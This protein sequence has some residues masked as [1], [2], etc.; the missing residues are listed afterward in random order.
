MDLKLSAQMQDRLQRRADF[1]GCSVEELVTQWLEQEEAAFQIP[2]QAIL[3]YAHDVIAL[4]DHDLRHVYINA[5][6]QVITG[7]APEAYLGRTAREMGMPEPAATQWE[8]AGASVFTTGE[9]A[10][11]D[12][13]F[14]VQGKN[15]F[16]EA[17]LSPIFDASGEVQY[18]L[19][20]ARDITDRKQIE[21]DLR[22]SEARLAQAQKIAH[23]AHWEWNVQTGETI[24][25]DEFCS[26]C[27]IDPTTE[28]PSLELG[29]SLIH[30]DDRQKAE[31]AIEASMRTGQ[32]YHVEKRILRS[33][34]SIRWVL[35]DGRVMHDEHG[36]PLKLSG[37]FLDITERRQDQERALQAVLEKMRIDIITRFI[38]DAAHEFRSP[39]T[40]ISAPLYLMV[41][42]DSPEKRE[43]YADTIHEQVERIV[44][45]V[46]MLT[47]LVELESHTTHPKTDIDVRSLLSMLCQ[48][49]ALRPNQP[50]IEFL[51]PDDDDF[52]RL[53]GVADYLTDAFRQLLDNAV[54]FT[55][56][57]GK[58]TVRLSTDDRRIQVVIED[59]GIGISEED[60]GRAFQSFWRKDDAHNTP[61]FGLGLPIARRA[62]RL[63]GGEIALQSREGSG[64][65]VYITLPLQK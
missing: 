39:L 12:F 25:S 28:P 61:G 8:E 31:T 48:Q 16:F 26:I 57:D 52:P 62:I 30:P 10:A 17:R 54:R 47:R 38:R 7:K 6:V 33:D 50:Q 5:H 32:P 43:H 56:P 58:I 3:N 59:T 40:L 20:I 27:G 63:H 24:W 4:F 45:L 22:E 35:S 29:L 51:A 2:Y 53:H 15:H 37:T 65:M 18:I 55:P 44:R 13:P 19:S 49:I 46:Q 14:P 11:V 60:Q 34:G 41:R 64:T 9:E 36:K 23:I 21:E 42:T 1:L